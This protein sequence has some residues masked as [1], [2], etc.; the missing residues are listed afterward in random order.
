[1]GIFDKIFNKNKVKL[2][3][4]IEVDNFE[5]QFSNYL[6]KITFIAKSDYK[7]FLERYQE[8]YN[9]F[10]TLNNSK[11]LDIYCK[12]N[13]VDYKYILLFLEHYSNCDSLIRDS[14]EKFINHAM[15]QEKKYFDDILKDI[16]LNIMLD[17]DQRKAVLTDED[18][19]LIIAGAGAGK[20][21]TVAAK[22]K[23]LVEKKGIDPKQIL[24]ISFTNKAV[25]ELKERINKNL[26]IECPITTFHSTGNAILRKHEN[27]KLNIKEDSFLYNVVNNYLKTKLLDISTVKNLILFFGTYFDAPYEGKDLIEFFNT[28][29]R[30]DYSTLRSNINE[31]QKTIINIREKKK[32]TINNE[33][34]RSRQEV[35]IA[36]FLYMN[37]IDYE[38]ESRYPY[39]IFLSKKPYTPDFKIIQDNKVAYIE[40]FGITEAGTHKFYSEEDLK[41]YQKAINDK[42]NIHKSHNTTLIYTY[43]SYNDR[44]ELLDHLKE[45]LLK[46]G[47]ELR[48]RNEEEVY[49]K[50]ALSEENKYISKMVILLCRFIS[51]FKTNGYTE[52]MF[53]TMLRK[54]PNVRTKLFLE[55][56]RECYLQYQK[57]L[58]EENAVDF[59]D[60]INESARALK[61]YPTLKDKIDFKYII[62]DEYQDIS[63]QRF[64][65]TK[66]LAN[67]TKSK[68]IAVGDDWQSIYA[69]S[70]SDISLF[71]KFCEKMGYGAELKI[72]NTYRNAQEVIDIAGNFVQKNTSQIKKSLKSFKHIED[73]VIIY[74]YDDYS[75]KTYENGEIV[76]GP[77]YMLSKGI[78]SAVGHIVA[79]SNK[80][81]KNILLIGRYGFDGK[82]LERS[83]LFDYKD[84]GNKIICK[85]YPQANIQFM[86]AHS[87]KGLGYDDVII[88]NASNE[89]YG[90]PCKIDDD[91]VLKLVVFEDDS[92]EFAEERRLFYVAMTRTKNRVYMVAPKNKPSEFVMELLEDYKNIIVD[93]DLSPS[94]SKMIANKAC[95]I[96]GYPLKYRLNNSYGLKLYMCTNEPEICNFISNDLHGGKMAIQK[97]T[98]CQ[99]G[100][101]IVKQTKDGGAILGCTNYKYDKT[102]CSSVISYEKFME[103]INANEEIIKFE[104]IEDSGTEISVTSEIEEEATSAV[105][106]IECHNNIHNKNNE[107]LKAENLDNTLMLE[108]IDYTKGKAKE[109]DILCWDVLTKKMVEDICN[110]KPKNLSELCLVKGIGPKKLEMYGKDILDIAKKYY[111]IDEDK[112]LTISE[113]TNIMKVD[114]YNFILDEKGAFK[115]DKVLFNKL[116]E[117]RAELARLADLP[118][119]CIISNDATVGLATYKPTTKNEF[120]NIKG[121]GEKKYE[122]YG[123]I[124][125]GLI[126]ECQRGYYES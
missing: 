49:D 2:K 109:K 15:V 119:Y 25:N 65:L 70:G 39:H 33:L 91:P 34:L 54:N 92:I 61:E 28:I 99:D 52:D 89:V 107:K 114:G 110:N 84:Y 13:S 23:Y 1:M 56:A 125:I 78:E 24:V 55:I 98:E 29:I 88:I 80:E 96:C 22:V 76:S 79:N 64:D 20:T 51:N 122:K 44:R 36:N 85:K 101:L 60:M 26:K 30:S 41:K 59:Q 83:N 21:T 72:I 31:F 35:Q 32:V 62:V 126:N 47:F 37:G 8:I 104:I 11:L 102:G 74:S 9:Y 90:F 38:Y 113:Q 106:I 82:N 94:E 120:I 5:S 68:I 48:P 111:K 50:L 103:N 77:L 73:P 75:K 53:Y 95:P 118:A 45:D 40:H 123:E 17:E 69:F 97:C 57:R 67:V 71:T 116:K 124:F 14:N 46:K 115:T 93:G 63:R 12:K 16:D 112:S 42:I 100:Y 58:S 43:S 18:Y 87:S 27:E 108:L 6:S 3:E 86:T 81:K 10:L 66:E 117:K 4:V 7:E 121:L 19:C 105:K